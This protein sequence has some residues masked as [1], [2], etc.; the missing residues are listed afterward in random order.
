MRKE[1]RIEVRI[2]DADKAR[3]QKAGRERKNLSAF[4]ISAGLEA[5]RYRRLLEQARAMER[6]GIKPAAMRVTK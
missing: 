6:A 5:I 2:S 3:L 1:N 4:L